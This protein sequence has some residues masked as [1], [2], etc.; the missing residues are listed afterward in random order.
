MSKRVF[1]GVFLSAIVIV[2]LVAVS[3]G[4]PEVVPSPSP[5]V[6]TSPT[7]K[8]STSV[9]PS[10]TPSVSPSPTKT[11]TPTPTPSQSSTPTPTSTPSPSS[12]TPT[13]TPTPTPSST[14]TPGPQTYLIRIDDFA[15]FPGTLNV[16][17]GDIVQFRNDES[18]DHSAVDDGGDWETPV[19]SE[20]ESYSLDT[21]DLALGTYRYHCGVHGQ[22][23]V[24][25]LRITP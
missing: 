1:I 5:S 24:G 4:T 6:S 18:F 14:P 15:F 21:S 13:P 20:G 22:A 23:M 11:P 16:H 3:R 19:L 2:V 12:G 25:T 9:S 7:P 10:R 17:P 8:A